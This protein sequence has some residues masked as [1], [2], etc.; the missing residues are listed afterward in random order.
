MKSPRQVG[1]GEPTTHLA[2]QQREDRLRVAGRCLWIALPCADLPL[3]ARSERGNKSKQ[4]WHTSVGH[5][6]HLIRQGRSTRVGGLASRIS[7]VEP[8]GCFAAW[9]PATLAIAR[10]VD[11][12]VKSLRSSIELRKYGGLSA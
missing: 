4:Q 9:E 2:H 11:P 3:N 7:A 8:T 6:R 12:G 1:D 10:L 5:A